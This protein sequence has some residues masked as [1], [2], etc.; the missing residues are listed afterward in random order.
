MCHCKQWVGPNRLYGTVMTTK[1]LTQ[2]YAHEQNRFPSQIVSCVHHSFVPLCFP[3]LLLPG[4]LFAAVCV[5]WSHM[6]TFSRQGRLHEAS[7]DSLFHWLDPHLVLC[8][9]FSFLSHCSAWLISIGRSLASLEEVGFL[10]D[11]VL[12]P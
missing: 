4:L 5:R 12:C 7:K 2:Q 1:Y 8:S 10:F 9:S 3:V 6:S 11:A